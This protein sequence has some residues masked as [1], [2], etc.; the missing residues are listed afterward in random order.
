ME[1]TWVV[2]ITI[3]VL[4][5]IGGLW[6]NRV[7]GDRRERRAAQ[8]AALAAFERLQ[9]ETHL[10][11][12]DA[13]VKTFEAAA[14]AAAARQAEA[15]VHAPVQYDA[16]ARAAAAD[17]VRA[18]MDEF[19]AAAHRAAVLE[20]RIDDSGIREL[21]M[22]AIDSSDALARASAP[23]IQRANDSATN[24]LEEAILELG[25]LVGQRPRA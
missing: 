3:P 11:L 25:L 17:K 19:H 4:T 9:R 8:A 18:T 23:K 7:D 15:A 21:A 24:A 14:R 13:L 22:A 2:T 5:F 16:A 10:E 20:S 6:W 1:W 12:Q